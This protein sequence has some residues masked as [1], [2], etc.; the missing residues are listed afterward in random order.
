MRS[1]NLKE[2]SNLSQAL[3]TLLQAGHTAKEITA[4]CG[5]PRVRVSQIAHGAE[6]ADEEAAA[7]WAVV[8][9]IPLN[10]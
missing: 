8:K 5:V 2:Q 7:L 6:A 4:L 10:D 3:L 1:E 9:I